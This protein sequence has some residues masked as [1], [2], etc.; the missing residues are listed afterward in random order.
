M[1]LE[2]LNLPLTGSKEEQIERILDFLLNP[3]NLGRVTAKSKLLNKL[4]VYV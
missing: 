4:Y 3:Q 2:A 1:F